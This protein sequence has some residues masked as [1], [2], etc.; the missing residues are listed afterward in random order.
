MPISIDTA[1]GLQLADGSDGARQRFANVFRTAW[2]TIPAA[3]QQR[4]VTWW[5]PGFAGQASPQV[6]LLANYNM[7]A[8]AEAFGHH[9]NF[10]SDVCDLMPDAILA[11]LIGHEL[12]HVWHYAQQ[13]SF[14]NT[15]GATHQQRENEAD[16]TADGWGFCMANL[17]AWAN[18]NA[19]AIVAATGNQNV[20]W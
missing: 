13:G 12:A 15:I 20:G 11:D 6:Q 4:I 7:A 19:T 16:A 18:A 14:A 1:S 8:A 5:Q 10:N 3:D 17:R 9:L 2:L